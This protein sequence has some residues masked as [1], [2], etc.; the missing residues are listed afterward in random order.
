MLRSLKA[1]R[2]YKI[3][4]TD[5]QIGTVDDFYF[6]DDDWN[7]RYMV[8]KTGHW[9]TGRKV[10][11]A[12]RVLGEADW[13]AGTFPVG[14]TCDQVR[15]CPSMETDKPVSRQQEI[16]LHEYF[17]WP[18][19]WVESP[20]TIAPPPV[21]TIQ[22]AAEGAT[23]EKPPANPNLRSAHEVMGYRV[24]ASDGDL[25]NVKDFIADDAEWTIR[26]LIVDLSAWM[27]TKKVLISPHWLSGIDFASGK[28]TVN[29]AQQ[30]IM[31][32][33]EFHPSSPV[34]REYEERL[35]DY[36][37]RPIYWAEGTRRK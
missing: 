6:T 32:C 20:L 11:I 24:H 3:L 22:V 30:P 2:Q 16:E 31:N 13:E 35:Y 7:V 5:G 14:L 10:L 18:H 37:G 29:M 36:Y 1:L 8:A 27:P 15:H 21:G 28:V 23:P 25:G 17:G 26:Y 12:T 19:Y 9:L 4:A 33:P 34:N